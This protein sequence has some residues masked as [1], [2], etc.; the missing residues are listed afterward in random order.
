MKFEQLLVNNNLLR[1]QTVTT[2]AMNTLDNR[3]LIKI[4]KMICQIITVRTSI[5]KTFIFLILNSFT[6]VWL[7]FCTVFNTGQI[8]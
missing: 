7:L 2:F 3:K 6:H 1:E 4:D 5:S 8:N